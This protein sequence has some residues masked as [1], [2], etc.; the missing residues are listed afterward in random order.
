MTCI[1]CS[2]QNILWGDYVNEFKIGDIV[3][4]KSY[5]GDIP[6]KIID[7]I[8]RGGN[9]PIYILKGMMYRIMA[10]SGGHDLIKKSTREV[11]SE[12][13]KHFY[14]AKRHASASNSAKRVYFSRLSARPGVILHL[15]ASKDFLDKCI[16]FYRDANLRPIGINVSESQQPGMVR[17]ALERYHPDI[18]VLTGHDSLKKGARDLDSL[19]NYSNSRYFISS[20]K[21][22]RK[23]ESNYDRLCIFAGA[24]QSHFEGIMR[25]GANF[26][27]SPKRILINALDPATVSKRVALTDS[28][29]IVHPDEVARLTISG[30]AGIGGIDTK[31]HLTWI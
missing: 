10:D 14:N 26:A 29:K 4:R 23:F 3:G 13:K 7:I 21:E 20:V 19:D 8:N 24:C 16:E 6:F 22:A 11:Y 31:G 27:S 18:L 9:E 5:G 1:L 15:D 17:R 25:A 30:T 12:I 2:I 28:R